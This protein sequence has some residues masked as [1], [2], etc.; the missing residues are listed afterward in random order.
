MA[1]YIAS[2]EIEAEARV[3]IWD[4]GTPDWSG[5]PAWGGN[6]LF[7]K[8][9][10]GATTLTLAQSTLNLSHTS[11]VAAVYNFT[12]QR[13]YHATTQWSEETTGTALPGYAAFS[14]STLDPSD[15]TTAVTDTRTVGGYTFQQ[16]YVHSDPPTNHVGFYEQF[17]IVWSAEQVD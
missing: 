8:K 12:I 10:S 7:L 6:T 11:E 15:G 1:K 3:A 5:T 13:R 2:A 4:P 14:S 9:D 17:D 16:S